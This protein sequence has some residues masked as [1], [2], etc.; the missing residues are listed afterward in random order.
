MI[1]HYS[2]S[3]CSCK[4]IDFYSFINKSYTTLYLT[5]YVNAMKLASLGIA[6]ISLK[7]SWVQPKTTVL[8]VQC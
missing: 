8:S 7:L 6:Y 2:E 4:Q 3:S 5:H 1:D